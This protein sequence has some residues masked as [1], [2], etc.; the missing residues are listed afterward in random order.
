MAEGTKRRG[1]FLLP[2]Q[3]FSPYYTIS[4]QLFD[5]RWLGSHV[6]FSANFISSMK[7]N[8][9]TFGCHRTFF[10]INCIWDR[11]IDILSSLPKIFLLNIF[12]VKEFKWCIVR[13]V[14]SNKYLQHKSCKYHFQGYDLDIHLAIKG[15]G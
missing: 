6:S 10:K 12:F 5:I 13:L 8:K 7:S 1:H 11:F 2:P 9:M 3:T 15:L 14:W 4:F